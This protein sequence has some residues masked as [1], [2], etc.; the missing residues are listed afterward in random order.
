MQ[1]NVKDTS[2]PGQNEISLP[3]TDGTSTE[4]INSVSETKTQKCSSKKH[5]HF[6]MD[7]GN[8]NTVANSSL[9]S[10]KLTLDCNSCSPTRV[11]A[12]KQMLVTSDNTTSKTNF[13]EPNGLAHTRLLPELIEQNDDTDEQFLAAA[14]SGEGEMTESL[15]ITASNNHV[16]LQD[17]SNQKLLVEEISTNKRQSE[18]QS[19]QNKTALQTTTSEF[20]PSTML[21]WED[22]S[23]VDEH[24][25]KC[26]FEFTNSSIFDLD[27]D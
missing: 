5:V 8:T 18:I 3:V 6:E 11:I 4:Q 19:I 15:E 25:T 16:K 21:S 14:N 9:V 23:K 2:A 7:V 10:D 26:S 24:K 20:A 13:L 1:Q 27:V 17:T 12:T 22:G